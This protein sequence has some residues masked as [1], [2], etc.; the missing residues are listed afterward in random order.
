MTLCDLCG[1]AQKGP[2]HG[3]MFQQEA[4]HSYFALGSEIL[5]SASFL[6]G[7]GALSNL[8]ALSQVMVSPAAI[9]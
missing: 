8:K 4:P 3:L 5:V 2:G 7:S 6:G 1:P 9:V